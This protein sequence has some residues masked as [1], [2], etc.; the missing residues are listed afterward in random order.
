MSE[1][2]VEKCARAAYEK[3]VHL[4][5]SIDDPEWDALPER[6]REYWRHI[7]RAAIAAMREPTEAMISSG[8]GRNVDTGYRGSGAFVGDEEVRE[9]W[10]ELID[11]ILAENQP[12]EMKQP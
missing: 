9:N 6:E 1:G 2:M 10:I 12:D 7:Q 8:R 11:T 3:S 5:P 4:D